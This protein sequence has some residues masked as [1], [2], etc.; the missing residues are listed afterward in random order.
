MEYC[1]QAERQGDKEYAVAMSTRITLI[2]NM[3]TP[4]RVPLLN[5]LSRH[6]G[7]QLS[8]VFLSERESNR[9]WDVHYEDLIF[10]Y[11]VLNGWHIFSSRLEWA[12]HFNPGLIRTLQRLSP[13]VV[14]IGGYTTISDWIGWAWA[15]LH[16]V[17][18]VLWSGSTLFS[19]RF[20]HGPIS[21]LRKVFIRG[22]KAYIAYGNKAAEFLISYGVEPERI[23]IGSNVGDVTFFRESVEQYRASNDAGANLSPQPHLLYVGRLTRDKGLIELFESLQQILDLPWDLTVV[24][25]GPMR[26]QIEMLAEQALAGR[27]RFVGF[28]QRDELVRYYALADVFIMPTLHDAA[29]IVLSEAL[30]AGLFV[31]G[32]RYDGSSYDLIHVSRNG[33][34]VDP[35]DTQGMT[36]VL[37]RV[38]VTHPWAARR[39]DISASVAQY[40]PEYYAN[41]F[42]QAIQISRGKT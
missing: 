30:A 11:T 14:I 23:A 9:Q 34:I 31:V 27:V 26:G 19:G 16:R 22:A 40:T 33:I 28:K 20:R 42:L 12:L 6:R 13:D 38:I 41:A 5:A 15:Q 32:S 3:V 39:K 35:K 29:S 1:W 36:K 7:L 4:Y 17:P 10:N 37:R 18:V 2:T 24:G 21:L 25:D 8:V